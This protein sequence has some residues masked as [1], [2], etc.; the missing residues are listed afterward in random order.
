MPIIITTWPVKKDDRFAKILESEGMTVWSMPMIEIDF[1]LFTIPGYLSDYDW[2]VFTSKNGAR[3]FLEQKTFHPH[4]KIA[5]IGAGTRAP[6]EAYGIQPDFEGTGQSGQKFADE[7][8][9]KIGVGKCILLA[10]GNMAPDSLYQALSPQNHVE[11]IN[12]YDTRSPEDV[13]QELLNR[14]VNDD[15]D[16]VAISSPSAIKNLFALVK[17]QIKV[18]LRVVS[19]GDTTSQAAREL[20]IEPLK[21]ATEQTYDGLAKCAVDLIRR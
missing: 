13:D 7:L 20:G 9:A 16:L 2:V 3:S 11:R 5:V 12:V 8:A 18:P 21:T 1:R 4:N 19:I 10:L 17:E 14:I 15:Y 6:F